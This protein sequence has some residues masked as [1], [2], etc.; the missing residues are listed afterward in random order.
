MLSRILPGL[1][2][3]LSL[4]RKEGSGIGR[5]MRGNLMENE[6]GRFEERGAVGF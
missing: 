3:E 6:E 1:S 2:G 4:K 5:G